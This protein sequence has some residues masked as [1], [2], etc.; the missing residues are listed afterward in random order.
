MRLKTG[1][2][3]RDTWFQSLTLTRSNIPLST[4]VYLDSQR[5]PQVM[6]NL[7][8]FQD[9]DLSLLKTMFFSPPPYRDF[10]DKTGVCFVKWSPSAAPQYVQETMQIPHQYSQVLQN[11][12]L[13][14]LKET[15]TCSPNSREPLAV[16]STKGILHPFSSSKQCMHLSVVCLNT[17]RVCIWS[18]Y[19]LFYTLASPYPHPVFDT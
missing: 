11:L 14:D 15:F 4:R 6:G 1:W 12:S 2:A 16:D 8:F 17:E 18:S 7:S 13:A 10:Q 3:E 9:I 5:V 19:L